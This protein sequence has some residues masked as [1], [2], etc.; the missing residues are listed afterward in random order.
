MT[1]KTHENDTIKYYIEFT[2]HGLHNPSIIELSEGY[3][4]NGEEVTE[5]YAESVAQAISS[6]DGVIRANVHYRLFDD[7][8]I[9]KSAMISQYHKGEQIWKAEEETGLIPGR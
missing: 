9:I 1:R 7:G 2:L 6:V 4:S 3:A 8:D 5:S